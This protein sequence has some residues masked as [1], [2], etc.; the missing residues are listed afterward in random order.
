MRTVLTLMLAAAAL[1]GC[2]ANTDPPAAEKAA[3]M[4][5]HGPAWRTR[6]LAD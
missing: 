4:G 6:S 2:A 3:A 1:A 5:Y